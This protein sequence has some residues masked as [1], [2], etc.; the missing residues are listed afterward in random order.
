MN[1]K[2]NQAI[3]SLKKYFYWGLFVCPAIEYLFIFLMFSSCR[4]FFI[5]FNNYSSILVFNNKNKKYKMFC[6][7]RRL[8]KNS[9]VNENSS[10]L[11]FCSHANFFSFSF[12]FVL[13]FYFNI[14]LFGIVYVFEF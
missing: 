2:K 8:N 12:V 10:G 13:V 6:I 3:S 9:K 5:I 4:S 1:V 14:L 11:I 7:R